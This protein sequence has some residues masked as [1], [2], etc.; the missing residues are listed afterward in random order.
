M[1]R[2]GQGELRDV[3]SEEVTLKSR[4]G[5]EVM[6]PDNACARGCSLCKGPGAG[7]CLA[8]GGTVKRPL[9]LEQAERKGEKGGQ[10]G[11]SPRAW[12]WGGPGRW[13]VSGEEAIRS[14][15]C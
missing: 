3:S 13:L 6:S 4:I 9:W 1:P 10:R 15:V 2:W 5:G 14:G 8:V 7:P 12:S 11:D